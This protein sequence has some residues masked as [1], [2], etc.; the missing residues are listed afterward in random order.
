MIEI[1]GIVASLFIILAFLFKDVR[2]IRILDTVGALL[3]VI[4]GILIHSWSNIFLNTV[5]ILIQIY[6][7]IEL[8]RNKRI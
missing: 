7:L 5:L 3:Y 6:R 8:K 1:L 4:Y 2:I